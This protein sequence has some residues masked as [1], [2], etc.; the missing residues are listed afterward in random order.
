MGH[1]IDQTHT[2]HTIRSS[3]E[4][5][6]GCP[7][8]R[9][10]K[11]RGTRP[12][13]ETTPNPK[14]AWM[15]LPKTKAKAKVYRPRGHCRGQPRTSL[16][17]PRATGRRR[18][19]ADDSHDGTRR[20]R[21]GHHA[22]SSPRAPRAVPVRPAPVS[23]LSAQSPLGAALSGFALFCSVR[24]MYYKNRYTGLA[25]KQ[26]ENKPKSCKPYTIYCAVCVRPRALAVG[27]V[28]ARDTKGGRAR[29][30]PLEA[31]RRARGGA[32]PTLRLST[33]LPASLH[34]ANSAHR[35][36]GHAARQ[37]RSFKARAR[38]AA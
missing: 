20:R 35:G 30:I 2:S 17:Q 7:T 21:A 11:R 27:V 6:P 36:R 33:P 28:R 15:H 8:A 14:T 37:G 19:G 32:R 31:E 3:Q 4:S 9:R 29:E 24:I 26:I 13:H 23:P 18:S 12:R 38:G 1:D 10:L 16:R 5:R 25:D 34:S 22:A